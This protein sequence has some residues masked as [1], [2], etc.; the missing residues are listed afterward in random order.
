MGSHKNAAAALSVKVA[1]L[2]LQKIEQ[3]HIISVFNFRPEHANTSPTHAKLTP[4]VR[5]VKGEQKKSS[6]QVGRQRRERE[7]GAKAKSLTKKV[8]FSM[9]S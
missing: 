8:C 6:T 9:L 2:P 3:S 7:G 4:D 5:L 1:S